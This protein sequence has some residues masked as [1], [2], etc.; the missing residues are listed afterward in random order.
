MIA[1]W[2]TYAMLVG[3]FVS[4][5]AIRAER[6]LKSTRVPLREIWATAMAATLLLTAIAIRVG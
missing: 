5:V 6:A 1:A 3:A 2:M 4:V